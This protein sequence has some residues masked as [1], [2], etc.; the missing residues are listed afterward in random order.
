MAEKTETSGWEM[1]R[2]KHKETGAHFTTTRDLATRGGHEIL[3]DRDALDKNGNPLP[4]KESE[5]I[6]EKA[7]TKKAGAK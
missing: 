2:V 4:I 6:T 7:A 5:S 1:V 3:T